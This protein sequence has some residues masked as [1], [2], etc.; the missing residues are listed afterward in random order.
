LF[1][2]TIAV[3][4]IAWAKPLYG[5]LEAGPCGWLIV[6]LFAAI[7]L[8][9]SQSLYWIWEGVVEASKAICGRHK[10]R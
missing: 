10:N 1:V 9:L 6:V 7:P 8:L 4:G 5:L 2:L 3:A